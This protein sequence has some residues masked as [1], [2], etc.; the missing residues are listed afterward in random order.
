MIWFQ[1]GDEPRFKAEFTICLRL[2]QANAYQFLFTERTY[3]GP[4]DPKM[5][6]PMLINM[7]HQDG[8]EDQESAHIALRMLEELNLSQIESHPGYQLVIHTLGPFRVSRGSEGIGT[9]DWKRQ[10]ARQLF[11]LLIT[12][13]GALLE[14][15][16]IVELLWP[17]LDADGGQRDFKIAY[18]TLCKVLEPNRGRKTPSAY[19]LR[20][21]TRYGLRLDADL[22]IDSLRFEQAYETGDRLHIADPTLAIPHYKK[23]VALYLGGYLQEYPYEEWA[24]EERNRLKMSYLRVATRLGELL[25]QAE[26][27]TDVIR[28][29]EKVLQQDNCQENT[30]LQMMKA[31]QALGQRPEAIRLYQQ[32]ADNLQNELA[33]KPGAAIMQLY[34]SLNGN[35]A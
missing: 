25:L 32:C 6:I 29:G 30:Y 2:I 31:Y 34:A 19:V 16:Q 17:E 12:Y 22:W 18:T 5:M 20:D 3:Y 14:R 1:S 26:A 24:D 23:A 35:S 9:G 8:A 27:W 7:R 21:G 15:E 4:P 11:Q 28:L 33:V 13:K 10:K